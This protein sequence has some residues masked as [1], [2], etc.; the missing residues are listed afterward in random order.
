MGVSPATDASDTHP[1]TKTSRHAVSLSSVS[2]GPS[3]PRITLSLPHLS[4][5]SRCLSLLCFAPS[6]PCIMPSLHPLSLVSRRLCP[7]SPSYHAVSAPPLPRVKLSLPHLSLAS[8]CLSP[9]RFAP[10]SLSVS[11]RLCPISLLRIKPSISPLCHFVSAWVTSSLPR[12][13]LV[14]SRLCPIPPSY[15]AVTTSHIHWCF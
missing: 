15:Q 8:R 1:Y 2:P 9:V 4:R 10:V 7:I 6:L 12:V 11:R 3:L 14:S 13:S 5:V